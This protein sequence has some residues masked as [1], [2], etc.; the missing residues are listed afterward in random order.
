MSDSEDE[1]EVLCPLCTE[2]MDLTDRTFRPCK[3]SYQICLW[4]WHNIMEN[5]GARCPACRTPY[6]KEI[7]APNP[8]LANQAKAE[9]RQK[10][11]EKNASKSSG[12]LSG[13]G[14]S[15][16]SSGFSG[17]SSLSS[18]SLSGAGG[19]GAPILLSNSLSERVTSGVVLERASLQNV[20]VMQRN[21]VYVIGL[22][23]NIAKEDLLKQKQY[24]GRFGKIV[25]V[26]VSNLPID[27]LACILIFSHFFSRFSPTL[28]W[29]SI[30][31]HF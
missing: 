4:C 24:F 23:P 8:S 31:T 15:G 26:G 29:K 3:C 16:A 13:S 2:A 22:S 21:L 27:D 7:K 9:Q 5:V 30:C 12:A 20:R 14:L 6:D 1:D 17:P 18:V 25:K 11:R 28:H 19:F 10:M